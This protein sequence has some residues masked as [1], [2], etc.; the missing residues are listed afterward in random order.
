[1]LAGVALG[2]VLAGATARIALAAGDANQP[3]CPP[4]TESSAGFRSF[5]PDCRAYELVTPPYTQGATVEPVSVSVDGSRLIGKSLG[6]F[7]GA[8]SYEFNSFYEFTRTA[9]GWS[10]VA[11]DP[12][13]SDPRFP[14]FEYFTA[15]A[16]LT[17]TL[18]EADGELYVRQE[19]PGAP[20]RFAA[21]GPTG[22]FAGASSDLD[23]VVI[24]RWPGELFPGDQ[25]T[26]GK[27]L[28]EYVGSEN[29]E[30][31]LV[32]VHNNGPL[33]GS[34]YVNEGAQLISE[35]GTEPGSAGSQDTYNAISP[36]GDTVF[37]TALHGSCAEP[38]LNE[39]YARIDGA[40]TAD[41]S[42]PILP[43][44]E[45]CTGVCASAARSEGVFQGASADGS[46]VF[47]LTAQPLLNADRDSS[48]DLYEAEL[49]GGALSRLV[50]VS[51]G[52]T[53]GTPVENDATPGEGADVL[54]VVRVTQDGSRV[55][56]VAEGVLTNTP[57]SEGAA[58]VA[59]APN[60]Y[61]YDTLTQ[62][63]A[64]LGTLQPQDGDLWQTQDVRPAQASSNGRFLVFAS[65]AH[66]TAD[67]T[68]GP[69]APQLFEYDAQTA[70]LTRVSIG[71]DGYAQDGNSD[72]AA[73]AP[74][75]PSPEYNDSPG[76]V[77]PAS[78]LTVT[79]EGAVVF[80]SAD[81][82]TPQVHTVGA[83]L[84]E[85]QGAGVQL[86]SDQLDETAHHVEEPFI[87]L[88]ASGADVFF[89]TA[90]Q[91][92]PQDTGTQVAW[93][94]ARAGG[95]FP[96][97]SSPPQCAQECE[98][99]GDFIPA[100]STPASA[101]YSAGAIAAPPVPVKPD[102][103]A[104][105]PTRAQRLAKALKACR[106]MRGRRRRACERIARARYGPRARTRTAAWRR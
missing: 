95:G 80:T 15:S 84:Y 35:C 71:Q 22:A 42:E 76:S 67:D 66:L 79:D 52:E 18:W 106:R 59:D 33:E 92:V 6:D 37:F 20:A 61:V 77:L 31:R 46:K 68:S 27:S 25:T 13:A 41:I 30:P 63:T 98:G 16:D 56:F 62:R 7:A 100:P 12:P 101:S 89:Q 51:E 53:H 73:D 105:V 93:Y 2:C 49:R 29:T 69:L 91:L 34:P 99:P 28:Y 45:Q 3:T 74:H 17:E 23:H 102:A 48:T 57:N 88:D 19:P 64:F 39:L 65:V 11:I 83:S 81:A 40:S 5:M 78:P 70:S 32:G 1:M 55:Y 97:P 86:I 103:K 26:S 4:E 94:D 44:G 96:A 43:A 82:L 8:E 75:I 9:A 47:F 85:Y 104:V 24:A 38:A 54:G 10:T 58:A 87:G 14:S 21:V 50:M 90:D 60:L 36:I 72:T